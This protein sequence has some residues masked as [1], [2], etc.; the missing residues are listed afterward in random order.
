MNETLKGSL[1]IVSEVK[2]TAKTYSVSI[3]EHKVWLVRHHKPFGIYLVTNSMMYNDKNL[4]FV[5]WAQS[6]NLKVIF[7]R[8]QDF[9]EAKAVLQEKVDGR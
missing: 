9:V 5:A 3:S 4:Q 6:H 1:H 7:G 8:S 2:M